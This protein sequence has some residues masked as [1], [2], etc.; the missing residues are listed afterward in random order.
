MRNP[1]I[2]QSSIDTNE[3]M[4][5]LKHDHNFEYLEGVN[6][7]TELYRRVFQEHFSDTLPAIHFTNE[8]V[9]DS[10]QSLVDTGFIERF[11]KEGSK[12]KLHVGMVRNQDERG[13]FKDPK[14]E[15]DNLVNLLNSLKQI[16]S[17][18]MSHGRRTNKNS[19]GE[20]RGSN[21]SQPVAIILDA[22]GSIGR[23]TDRYYHW[24]LKN[25]QAPDK[26][27]ELVRFEAG[28]ASPNYEP[29]KKIRNEFVLKFLSALGRYRLKQLSAEGSLLA[30]NN[31]LKNY[32]SGLVRAGLVSQQEL[33]SCF[34][35]PTVESEA[36][37]DY[38]IKE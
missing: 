15:T 4:P 25:H 17:D 20:N 34:S 7:T 19:L 21:Y 6:G 31:E 37:V 27:I 30:D 12:G 10:L 3:V 28:R 2:Y 13:S 29:N 36:F 14:F 26:I 16:A 24:V 32:A 22:G 11:E 33:D 8:A 38:D 18:F 23:G 5:Q 9:G 35:G 1:E